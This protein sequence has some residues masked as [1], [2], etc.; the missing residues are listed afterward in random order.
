MAAAGG[1]LERRR[2]DAHGACAVAAAA[3]LGG[4]E[5]AAAVDGV[6]AGAGRVV[7]AALAVPDAAAAEPHR[8][9]PPP[10]D[11]QPLHHGATRPRTH[12]LAL[13]LS[14]SAP[15]FAA[16]N[17]PCCTALRIY[18]GRRLSFPFF[19]WVCLV[20]AKI[21]SLIEIGIM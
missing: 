2:G 8:R 20:H 18:S 5:L 12:T 21:E 1:A 11:H 9:L 17:P 16:M 14:L 6:A 3:V 19:T 15:S 4:D 13:L 7:A 10:Q